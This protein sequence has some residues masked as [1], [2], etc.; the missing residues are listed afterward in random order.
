MAWDYSLIILTNHGHKTITR[1]VMESARP[2]RYV[3]CLLQGVVVPAAF[4]AE[5]IPATVWE[6]FPG[7]IP[8]STVGPLLAEYR[9]RQHFSQL[10][11]GMVAEVSPRHIS[12]IETGRSQPSREMLLRLADS[13]G[14][15]LHE[16]NL[17]L[18]AAG[19]AAAYA[20]FHLDALAMQ[21]VREALALM[22]EKQ[23]PYPALVLDGNWNILMTNTGQQRLTASLLKGKALPD[24]VN[25]LEL[26][27]DADG[28][29][30]LIANW[31]DVASQ[32]LRRLRR[33][34][35]AY[36]RPG[37]TAL[38]ERLLT[39]NPPSRWQQP[40][41]PG[42]DAPVLT[43]DIR[44][45]HRLVKM[46][47]TLSQFGTALDVGTEEIHIENYFPANQDA[48]EFFAGMK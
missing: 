23:N 9:R 14:L 1:E 3:C 22:L 47:S 45:G 38:L 19:Y 40:R 39:L 10:D 28:Y 17:L 6:N 41:L 13:L 21:P 18:H 2:I 24:T 4:P 20:S 31:E 5:T 42:T 33:Q 43:V 34:V 48:R 29:R 36:S 15:S 35:I 11:L 30:P 27:F 12:F 25:L 44:V 26:V 8:V 46:F 7:S 16:S 32:L 37:H